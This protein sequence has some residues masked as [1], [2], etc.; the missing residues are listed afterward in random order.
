VVFKTAGQNC[1]YTA[2]FRRK[3]KFMHEMWIFPDIS[4]LV[5]TVYLIFVGVYLSSPS[6]RSLFCRSI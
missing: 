3:L 4:G 1:Q 6:F 2:S 5:L